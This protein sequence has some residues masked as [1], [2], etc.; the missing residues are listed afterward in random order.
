MWL[1]AGCLISPHSLPLISHQHRD[2][3]FTTISDTH[4]HTLTH[5]K[6]LTPICTVRLTLQDYGNRL[7]Q[8]C[9][10]AWKPSASH[11][12]TQNR[13]VKCHRRAQIVLPCWR[14][15][16]SF[17]P[18]SCWIKAFLH[19]CDRVSAEVDHALTYIAPQYRCAL[20]LGRSG[21]QCTIRD[22]TLL[23]CALVCPQL[24][25]QHISSF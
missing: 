17:I 19:T 8:A 10:L 21:K 22:A 24:S 7:S 13:A 16:P 6:S 3:A 2:A 12:S 1:S 4:R 9:Q 14:N 23:V 15:G 25:L 5:T 11:T 18:F 20:S